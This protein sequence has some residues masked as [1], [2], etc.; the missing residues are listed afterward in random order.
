M[1][2]SRTDACRARV[3]AIAESATLAVDAKAKALKAAGE[4]VIGFGAGEPDF[5]TPAHI[6]EAAVAALPRPRRTTSTRPAAGL[7]ELQRG[8]RRQDAARLRL[9]GDRPRRCSSPTAASTPSTTP[10]RRCCDPGDEV[11]CPAPYWT[12][13]PEAIALAGGVPVVHRH[14][15]GDRLPGHGRPARGGPHRA[16]Q[17]A[18][19]RVALDNP[20]G[21]VYL[22]AEVEAI[23]ALGGG[24]GHLGHHRRDLRA[25]DLR[26]RTAHVPMPT[27]VPDLADQLRDRQRRRQDLRDDRLARRLDDRPAR[28]HQGGD[29]PPEPLHLERGQRLPGEPRSPPS[30]G[31]LSAR[32]RDAHRAS[33]AAARP[34]ARAAQAIA[35]VTALEPQGAFYW[36][37]GRERPRSVKPL[38]R[39]RTATEHARWS[40]PT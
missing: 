26:R 19:V 15:R 5:P 38:G 17:G 12:T 36:L 28:R 32:R 11:L 16:H 35:G 1:P 3:A 14:R 10:S 8:H 13:Y 21:A 37:P 2:R 34:D 6:V 22:R 29:Q 40:S 4:P 9:R 31:D 7:P 25:P 30:R 18:A 39:R 24:A 23:G 33:S 27:L 20:T